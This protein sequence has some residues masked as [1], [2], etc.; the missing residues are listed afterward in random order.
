[1]RRLLALCL[2]ALAVLP[3]GASARERWDTDVFALIPRPGFPAMAYVA[4]NGRVYEGTYDNPLGDS[5]PSRV[6]EFRDDGTLLRSWVIGGQDLGGPHGVQV[7]TFDSRGR[8]VLLDK[9]PARVLTLDR[10]TGEQRDYARFPEGAV[11]NYSAWGPD[12]SLYVTDYEGATVWR[13]PPGGGTP[14]P[15]LQDPRLDGGPFG[16]TGLAL[17]AEVSRRVE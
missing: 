3:A 13:V 16:T 1:M 9:S 4:P 11:P 6:F 8:L 17:A 7:G 14:E 5:V 10:R 2:T 12:G 15:W